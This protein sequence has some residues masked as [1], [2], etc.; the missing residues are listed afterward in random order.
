MSLTASALAKRFSELS[1]AELL[2]LEE[3]MTTLDSVDVQAELDLR[4]REVD[5]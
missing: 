4:G 1:D 5:A 2:A 3:R